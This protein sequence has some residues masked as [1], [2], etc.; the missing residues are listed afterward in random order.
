M[1]YDKFKG[2]K[3]AMDRAIA[4]G[5]VVATNHK[6]KD[7]L[8]FQTLKA[9]REKATV[10]E[11]ALADG[12]VKLSTDEHAVIDEWMKNFPAGQ[13]AALTDGKG[14]EQGEGDVIAKKAKETPWEEVEKVLLKARTS[15][16]KLIKE[17]LKCKTVVLKAN[18]SALKENLKAILQTLQENDKQLDHMMMWQA[19]TLGK[20]WE[21][22][23]HSTF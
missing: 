23:C 19:S 20:L 6:G 10:D 17:T 4:E 2:N 21:R 7:F 8:T 1:L 13:V 15:Q 11:T 12:E 14:E 16:Q 3:E 22:A 9:G 5:D 18:D